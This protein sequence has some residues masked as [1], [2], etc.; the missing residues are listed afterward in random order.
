MLGIANR[1]A[2][3]AGIHIEATNIAHGPFQAEMRRRLWWALVL[4][5]ARIAEMSNRS[6][7]MLIPTWDCAVPLNVYDCQLQPGMT[8]SPPAQAQEVFSDSVFVATRCEIANFVRHAKFHVD[9]VNSTLGKFS[10]TQESDTWASA[11]LDRLVQRQHSRQYNEDNSVHYMSI[12]TSQSTAAKYGLLEYVARTG[13]YNGRIDEQDQAHGMNKALGMLEATTQLASSA[14]LKKFTWFSQMYFPFI[15]YIEICQQLKRRPDHPNA[16]HIWQVMSENYQAC[17]AVFDKEDNPFIT[18][19]AKI[20]LQ[21][22]AAREGIATSCPQIV[23]E[24]KMRLAEQEGEAMGRE[25][26]VP[27]GLPFEIDSGWMRLQGQAF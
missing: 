7:S 17:F 18:L 12:V 27:A 13:N 11:E 3:R 19:F 24:I 1:I 5:D 23:A 16:E 20:V 6:A 21:A 15:A 14:L 9:S 4:F 10:K 22:W 26:E 2:Q 25:E 8:T